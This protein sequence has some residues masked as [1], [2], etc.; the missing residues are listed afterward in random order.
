M[1]YKKNFYIKGIHI[2]LLWKNGLL[3]CKFYNYGNSKT[4]LVYNPNKIISPEILHNDIEPSMKKQM[5]RKKPIVLLQELSYEDMINKVF[6]FNCQILDSNNNPLWYDYEKNIYTH[7]SKIV[8]EKN[9]KNENNLS[10]E[11]LSSVFQ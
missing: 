10:L 8:F 3:R 2:K 9:D 6:Y 11:R 7:A 1:H 5:I 4:F